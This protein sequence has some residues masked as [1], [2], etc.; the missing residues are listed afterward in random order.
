M[1]ARFISERLWSLIDVER[2]KRLRI[3]VGQVWAMVN[4]DGLKQQKGKSQ[5]C[6]DVFLFVVKDSICSDVLYLWVN[7]LYGADHDIPTMPV[8]SKLDLDVHP[9]TAWL[10]L[11]ILVGEGW[12]GRCSLLFG[13]EAG[14]VWWW[15]ARWWSG[16]F[17]PLRGLVVWVWVATLIV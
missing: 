15:T 12:S 2:A 9:G 5:I 14:I 6:V 16:F 11:C 1:W 17:F 4:N 8:F 10:L 7:I 3:H 13:V